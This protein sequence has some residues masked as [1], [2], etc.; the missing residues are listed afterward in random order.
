[1]AN[2]LSES[3]KASMKTRIITGIV[4]FLVGLPCAIFG[5][6]FLSTLALFL[7]VVA[8]IEILNV[9]GKDKFTLDVKIVSIIYVVFLFISPFLIACCQGNDP[10][11]YQMITTIDRSVYFLVP[12]ILTA[13]YFVF[14]AMEV[15][16]RE[17]FHIQDLGFLVSFLTFIAAGFLSLCFLR[18]V[19]YISSLN[20]N[21]YFENYFTDQL[22]W[23]SL[24]PTS[25]L[26]FIVIFSNCCCDIFAYFVG[27]LFG[28]HKMDERI[29]PNKTWEGFIGG[30]ICSAIVFFGLSL[31]FEF[32]FKMPL[33]PGVMQYT[34]CSGGPFGGN[35]FIG[36]IL[37]GLLIPIVG[38]ISGF[39][40]SAI[41]RTYNVKDYG[42][43]FPG[44]GGVIDRF[45][46]TLMISVILSLIISLSIR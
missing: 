35:C 40:F 2:T 10:F 19:P 4:M 17:S 18:N 28:K 39:M 3:S 21:Y 27:S 12:V 6:F 13:A 25:L 1:M 23:K 29:S 36:M 5:S 24:L 7:L 33:L 34:F 42:R 32:A 31:L 37:V 11:K 16:L 45:D 8:T 20:S 15:V 22:Y 26:M 46:S 38:N 9:Q 41:K 44:H 30:S 14:L 43:I